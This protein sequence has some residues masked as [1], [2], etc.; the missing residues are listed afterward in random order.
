MAEAPHEPPFIP[1]AG[2]VVFNARNEVLL[3]RQRDGNW[4]FPK[5][6]IDPGEDPLKAAMREVAEEAGV[7]TSCPD[8]QQSWTTEYI[9]RRGE[10]RRITWYRLVTSAGAPVMREAQFPEGCFVAPDRARDLLAFPEDRTLLAR[11]VNG[12]RAP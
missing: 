3:I 7:D 2:G 5:G 4:V 9:N 1:G 11:V 12:M 6:H 8:P 10:R